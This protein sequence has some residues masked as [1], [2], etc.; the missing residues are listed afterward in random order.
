M[1]ADYLLELDKWAAVED[2]RLKNPVPMFQGGVEDNGAFSEDIAEAE[3]SREEMLRASDAEVSSK[4]KKLVASSVGRVL[5]Q[6]DAVR[7]NLEEL[8]AVVDNVN[9]NQRGLVKSFEVATFGEQ[10]GYGK[11]ASILQSLA[12]PKR[13]IQKE[14]PRNLIRALA[15]DDATP[16]KDFSKRDG[17]G[18]ARGEGTARGLIKALAAPTPSDE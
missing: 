16:E 7:E 6:A 18:E 14:A 15:Q 9:E 11:P 10:L 5:K 13:R 8:R 3:R 12:A 1:K 4:V 2:A 17:A